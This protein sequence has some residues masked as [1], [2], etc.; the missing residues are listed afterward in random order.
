MIMFKC[1][2]VWLG[3]H[4]VKNN[5]NKINDRAFSTRPPLTLRQHPAKPGSIPF[6]PHNN[7]LGQSSCFPSV[8]D[9]DTEDPRV[10]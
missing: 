2:S 5:N 8:S 9:S 10:E 3:K 4:T 7:A 1:K 6:H